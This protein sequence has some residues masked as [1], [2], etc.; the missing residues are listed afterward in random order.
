MAGNLDERRRRLVRLIH[1]GKGKLGLSDDSYVTI[2]E[3]ATGKTSST[4][5]TIAELEKVMVAMRAAG[6]V[7]T[8]SSWGRS[9]SVRPEDIGGATKRQVYYIKGLWALASRTKSEAGLRSIIKRIAGVDDL[10][11]LPRA[12]ASAI[13]LALRDIAVKSGYE[14]DGIIRKE[15]Q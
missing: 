1:V 6:F 3:G 13:I 11:F 4:E 12:K 7:P 2:L 10:R 15:S 5:M 14:P 8:G 9:L